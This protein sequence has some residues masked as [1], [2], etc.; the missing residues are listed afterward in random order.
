MGQKMRVLFMGN[1]WV[2]WQVV[3]WLRSQNVEIA[4]LVLHP[5]HKRKYGNEIISAAGV[6]PDYIFDGSTLRQPETIE[7]IAALQAD[8]ALSILFDYILK[9]DIINLFPEGVINLHPSYL[10][11][12][13]G[14]YPNVWS[15]VEQTPA[16]VTLMYIDPGIDTG[17]II[18]RRRIPIEPVDTGKT[19]YH[20]LEQVSLELF[21]DTWPLIRAGQASRLPQ[22]GQTGT[23]HR[24]KDV[25]K[26]DEIDLDRRYTARELIDIIRARTFPP[27]SGAYFMDN[28]RKVYLRLQLLYEEQLSDQEEK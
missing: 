3:A 24:T 23:C 19:L 6:R 20:K 2:G 27:Y 11:Y 12:N 9:P 15:I 16:G 28:G 13:R 26:I 22:S 8:M 21:K 7:A 18:A 17:D 25:K 4:G 14:Q 5:P 1:N 10:P